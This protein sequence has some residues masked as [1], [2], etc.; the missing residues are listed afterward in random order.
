MKKIM[1]LIGLMLLL[2][3]CQ[4]QEKQQTETENKV[5]ESIELADLTPAQYYVLKNEGTE[6]PYSSPL[7]RENRAGEM[8][9]VACG[10]LLFENENQYDANCGWPS[11]DRAVE[12][13][14]TY[15]D[16]YK[17]GYKRIEVRCAKCDGHL[18]HVFNDGPK[19]TTG[20]RYCINGVALDFTPET[21][22]LK[23]KNK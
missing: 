2:F 5:S 6:R 1:I 21:E 13:A 8:R 10:N 11:F 18:G 9:C 3:S 12:G 16:D 19:N 14:V 22:I 17:L 4:A 7:L 20:K 23:I 15:K